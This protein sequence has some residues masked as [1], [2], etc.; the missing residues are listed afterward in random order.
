MRREMT[1][2]DG[3]RKVIDSGWDHYPI[4][5]GQLLAEVGAKAR[6]L[7]VRLASR[8]YTDAAGERTENSVTLDFCEACA[9]RLVG[10]LERIAG[11]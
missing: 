9:R 10:A 1:V 7:R 6:F 8:R 3:C 2:C 11:S 4:P 5:A